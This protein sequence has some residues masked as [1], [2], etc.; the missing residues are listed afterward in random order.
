MIP[1]IFKNSRKGKAI[2]RLGI[3]EKELTLVNGSPWYRERSDQKVGIFK[4]NKNSW[5]LGDVESVAYGGLRSLT[6]HVPSLNEKNHKRKY[7][8]FKYMKVSSKSNCPVNL[9]PWNI[10]DG[11]KFIVDESISITEEPIIPERIKLECS[12][13]D[14]LHSLRQMPAFKTNAAYYKRIWYKG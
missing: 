2:I 10:W 4:D 13:M 3:Y 5:V 14:L 11:T 8:L 12:D 7:E 9:K 6:E 1:I